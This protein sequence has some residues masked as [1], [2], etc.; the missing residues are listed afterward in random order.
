MAVMVV[1][2]LVVAMV[3]VTTAARRDC[4]AGSAGGVL[5]GALIPALPLRAALCPR[6]G[7][8]KDLKAEGGRASVCD[9]GVP[10]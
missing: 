6:L 3:R 8:V 9:V 5:C 2:A 10:T 4:G 7:R 1:V